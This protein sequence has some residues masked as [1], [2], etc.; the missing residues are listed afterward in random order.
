MNRF[1]FNMICKEIAKIQNIVQTLEKCLKLSDFC[2]GIRPNAKRFIL[3]SPK[4]DTLFC[5]VRDL[6]RRVFSN[7][8]VLD[9]TA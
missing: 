1:L 8:A 9:K 3:N 4:L 7:P 6:K 2:F 5:P